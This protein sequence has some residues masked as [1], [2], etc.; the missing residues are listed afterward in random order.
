MNLT[1]AFIR[2]ILYLAAMVPPLIVIVNL[3][4]PAVRGTEGG[5]EHGGHLA[6]MRIDN[7]L[8]Q[9]N[10]G[11]IDPAGEA[12]KLSSLGL[13]GVAVSD[14]WLK[15][16]HYKKVKDFDRLSV[17]VNQLVKLQPNFITV[18]EFQAHNLS[19]NVSVEFD[20]YRDR[21]NWVTKGIDFL[22]DGTQYNR[23]EPHLMGSCGWFVSQKIGRADE[24][25][26]FRRLFRHDEEFQE[27]LNQYVNV[28]DAKS[29]ADLYPDNWLVG[30]LWYL[31]AERIVETR[32]VRTR[33]NPWLFYSHAPRCLI[34]YATALDRD[35]EL[36]PEEVSQQ[37]WRDAEKQWELYGAREFYIRNE[38]VR[39]NSLHEL[40]YRANAL[41]MAVDAAASGMPED[42]VAQLRAEAERLYAK[43]PRADIVRGKIAE[44]YPGFEQ[45]RLDI[46]QR[47]RDS[48]E[49][50]ERDAFET[51]A[52]L[53][54]AEQR[55]MVAQIQ[56]K[57]DPT[58]EDLLNATDEAN[59]PLLAQLVG[60]FRELLEELDRAEQ[61][62]SHSKY[63]YWLVRCQVE[64]TEQARAAKRHLFQAKQLA[65]QAKLEKEETRD[66]NGEKV[67]VLGAKEHYEAAWDLWHDIFERRPEMYD[68][69][70][71]SQMLIQDL[72]EYDSILSKLDL[73][74]LPHDFKLRGLI[75]FDP[76][77]WTGR[78]F[79][80]PPAEEA[81]DDAPTKEPPKDGSTANDS[82]GSDSSPDEAKKQELKKDKPAE[83]APKGGD[84]GT[85]EAKPD[86]AKPAEAKP[87]ENDEQKSPKADSK[88]KDDTDAST[89]LESS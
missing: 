9:S 67:V 82:I 69:V 89:G 87:A 34:S 53:R 70:E 59:L 66:E 13:R 43:D 17:T 36:P 3:G 79:L 23:N 8:A 73:D 6:Q 64:S 60:E 35:G 45:L 62:D 72:I 18:R 4:M 74:P 19:Y 65:K 61:L 48:L 10:L 46:R 15:A 12:M 85:D 7:D 86:E 32:N 27:K 68:N 58:P 51:P 54:T 49:G 38:P 42:E 47:R 28:D 39:L 77:L 16:M 1:P 75:D 25:R 20:D 11:E 55:T 5:V 31:K 21:Y 81:Q 30:R 84:A 40:R 50:E 26:Q 37:A 2:K 29:R 33:E 14:L 63:H 22:M 56:P 83:D 88:A 57:F 76:E 24:F 41:A 52:E 80:P 78:P 71:E 44:S